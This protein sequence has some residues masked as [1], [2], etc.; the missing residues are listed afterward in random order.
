MHQPLLQ[1][2]SRDRQPEDATLNRC[3]LVGHQLVDH[4]VQDGLRELLVLD[5]LAHLMHHVVQQVDEFPPLGQY[6][7]QCDLHDEDV[8]PVVALW[9]QNDANHP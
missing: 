2:A 6:Q 8:Q 9:F 5:E 3:H 7:S 4:L 1:L